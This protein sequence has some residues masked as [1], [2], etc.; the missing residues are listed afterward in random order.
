[1]V[2]WQT[3]KSESTARRHPTQEM[4]W[5]RVVV[6]CEQGVERWSEGRPGDCVGFL[7]SHLFSRDLETSV[8]LLS[9]QAVGGGLEAAI[10]IWIR[11]AVE[12]VGS[13]GNIRKMTGR[14]EVG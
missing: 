9:G 12:V 13:I 6:T 2:M 7:V 8:D 1:M 5:P 3:W 11:R 4:S 10:E 14:T